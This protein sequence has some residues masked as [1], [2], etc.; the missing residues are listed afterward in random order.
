VVLLPAG[1]RGR[2]QRAHVACLP[3]SRPVMA[4]RRA[5]LLLLLV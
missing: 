3:A 5:F 1:R 2:R 4:A